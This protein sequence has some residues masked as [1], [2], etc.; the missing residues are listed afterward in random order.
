MINHYLLGISAL[1]S[2]SLVCAQPAFTDGTAL[3]GHAAHSGGCMAITDMDGDG[4]D[5]VVQLDNGTHV[6]VIYQEEDGSFTTVDYGDVDGSS[7]WG[8]AIGDL[9]NDGHKDIC[10]GATGQQNFL[11]ITSRGAYTLSTLDGPSIFTQN[12]SMADVDN[13]GRVDI[14]A[15]NDN[16]APN[17]WFTPASGLPAFNGSFIDWSTTPI[18]DMSGNY[19]SSFI[20]FDNDGDMDL[21]ISHCRQGVNNPNDPR[22]WNRLFVNDGNNQYTDQAAA[23]GADDHEQTWTTDFGD[24]DNDGDLDMVSNEHS[25]GTQ[26]F[27]N[28]GTGHFTNVTAGSGLAVA[29]FPLQGMFRDLDN[30]GFLDVMIAGGSEYYYKGNGDGTFTP[31]AGLFPSSKAMHSFAFG[32]LN[33]DGFEDVYANYG[34]SYVT[35]SGTYA[36]RLWLN[37]PNGNH[38]FRVMLQGVVSNRD[39]IGARVTITGPWGTQIREVRSGE[40]YGLVNSFILPFGLGA[41]NM[42]PTMSVRWPS[43]L[44]ETFNDLHADQT[45]TV[46]E[47]TCISPNV[48]I[49]GSPSMALCPGG[50]TITLTASPGTDFTWNTGMEGAAITVANP[51]AYW[52]TTGTG[53]CTTQANANVQLSPDQTPT[54]SEEG[55]TTICPTDE[56]VLTASAADNYLWSNGSDQQSITVNTAGEYTVTVQGACD[57]FTSAPITV[58]V[59]DAPGA[60]ASTD[61]AIPV[62]GTAVLTAT[63]DSIAWYDAAAGGTLLGTGS[64]WTTPVV[65]SNT[66]FWC[67]AVGQNGGDVSYGGKTDRSTEGGYQSNSTY[68]LYFSTTGDMVIKSVKVYANGDD[69]RTIALVEQN[70]GAVLTSGVYF[71]PDGESRVELDMFVPANGNYGLRVTSGDPQLW[72][73]AVGSNPQF[74]YDLGGLGSITGSNAS[75]SAFYYFFYDWEVATPTHW[76]EGPRTAVQVLVGGVG[77]ETQYAANGLRLFPNPA[78]EYITVTGQFPEGSTL[79]EFLDVSGRV[80]LQ[81][82]LRAN[83]GSINVAPLAPGAYTVRIQGDHAVSN[84][85][86]VKE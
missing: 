82:K 29:S 33:R 41:E 63:G 46:V 44:E 30:D 72:R 2:T 58:N 49:T 20:D 56:V 75:S 25:T 14:F 17:L 27:E 36:D 67:A 1:L 5:D 35:P 32:D 15:C 73:D 50:G 61:V 76:C 52:A 78:S 65:N 42:V 9:Y 60:P 31:V 51:G 62:P 13:D 19:G 37:T 43:G 38:F 18:S 57:G 4:L 21:Y 40:S 83:E 23:H 54:V 80:C 84:L 70:G 74:P 7:Q 55:A 10:S 71:I 81:A 39:A 24:Y 68:Y 28:D 64:P 16:G 12:M 79:A 11:S 34:N 53:A 45:I 8:W 48:A 59:L 85:S 6:F 69:Y 3:L 77:I 66:T 47:G 26:L 86:F 22:R